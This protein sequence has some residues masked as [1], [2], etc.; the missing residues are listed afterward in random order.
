MKKVTKIFRRFNIQAP[1]GFT[2]VE[3]LIAIL[4]SVIVITI[5]GFALATITSLD[6]KAEARIERRVDLSRAFDFIS[7]EIKRAA[8]I[9]RTAT[10]VA[11]G[12]STSLENVITSS[13]L[14]L[15]DL[16]SYGTIVLYLEI[17]INSPIG[18][19]CPAGSPNA[20][21]APPFPADYD[22]VVYDIRPSTT[23]WLGPST[24]NRYG[25][26]PDVSGKINPCSNP[27]AGDILVDSISDVYSVLDPDVK[28][29]CNSPAIL[30]GVGGFYACVNGGQV[31]LYLRSK[32]IDN[33]THN[34]TN[35]AFSRSYGNTTGET[36]QLSGV[37]Q[38]AT[39]NMNLV[40]TWTGSSSAI[41]KLYRSVGG[42]ATELY[43]GSSL[44][45][46]DTLNGN[47]GD[48]NCYTVTA[49]IG[50]YTTPAS[51]AACIVK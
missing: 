25:R 4:I 21:S 22:I 37:R 10:M 45:F 51:K 49:T 29:I 43:S 32:V 47:K 18:A 15:S 33:E 5:A 24:I 50:S 13:G 6:K 41:F 34:L 28:P 46:S 2:L 9:N 16:G 11:D 3:L 27:V 14:N 35:K 48:S 17:P 40:W 23:T 20:G 30:S 44:N 8:R 42:E 19:I 31:E 12:F 26:I 7:Y 38:P 1:T 36:P 39:D